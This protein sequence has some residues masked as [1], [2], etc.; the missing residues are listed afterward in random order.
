MLYLFHR[1]N[2]KENDERQHRRKE[3]ES[4]I[5]T[6]EGVSGDPT[7][8]ETKTDGE[9]ETEQKPDETPKNTPP[10]D[11]T[12]TGEAAKVEQTPDP[13][14]DGVAIKRVLFASRLLMQGDDVKAVHA[15]LIE[16]GLHVGTDSKKG[17]YG[18]ATALA[19]RHFQVRNR[20]IV[21]GRVGKFTARALGFTLEG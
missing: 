7:E 18:T 6:P 16:N 9:A 2:R 13:S 8:E 14:A 1:T 4:V 12:K 11:D 17:I 5:E 3:G 15:A 20:L 10:A 21:D 19:V